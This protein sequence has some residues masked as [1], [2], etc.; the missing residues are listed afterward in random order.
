MKKYLFVFLILLLLTG[1][2]VQNSHSHTQCPEC[3]K[4]ISEDCNGTENGS[5]RRSR[6]EPS[7]VKT[8]SS[9]IIFRHGRG[10]QT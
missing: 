4:C 8:G 3:S 6:D 7:F 10:W 5:S 9:A 1:C 2:N